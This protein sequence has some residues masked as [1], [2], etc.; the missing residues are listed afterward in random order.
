MLDRYSGIQN[1]NTRDK[2]VIPRADTAEER[3]KREVLKAE[4]FR[5]RE[6][7]RKKRGNR[8]RAGN[9]CSC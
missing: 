2:K 7:K 1:K 3:A 4:A 6:E 9:F 5:K 8:V